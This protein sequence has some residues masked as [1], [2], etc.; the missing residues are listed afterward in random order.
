MSRKNRTNQSMPVKPAGPL[1]VLHGNV[2][3]TFLQEAQSIGNECVARRAYDADV[4]EYLTQKGLFEEWVAW[5]EAKR[6]PKA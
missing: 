4:A 1:P 5:R 2:F 3:A 6:A